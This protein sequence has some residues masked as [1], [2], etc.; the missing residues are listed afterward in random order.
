MPIG[1]IPEPVAILSRTIWDIP[2]RSDTGHSF[3]EGRIF[4]EMPVTYS[5]YKGENRVVRPKQSV[6]TTA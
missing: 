4:W 1:E 5:L 3:V 6:F 2:A